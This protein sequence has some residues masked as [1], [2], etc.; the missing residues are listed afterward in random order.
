MTGNTRTEAALIVAS[1]A[2]AGS[3]LGLAVASAA[4]FAAIAL[5]WPAIDEILYLG[6][7]GGTAIGGIACYRFDR[8]RRFRLQCILAAAGIG[9]F[10]G[11]ILVF[12][13]GNAFMQLEHERAAADRAFEIIL[14]MVPFAMILG[15][16]GGAALAA[17]TER[18]MTAWSY[19]MIDRFGFRRPD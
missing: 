18:R 9:A 13:G 14:A 7:V 19:A 16:I 11:M 3:A 10:A 2:L 15:G 4:V 5:G 6:L 17:A 12:G 8:S 1:A